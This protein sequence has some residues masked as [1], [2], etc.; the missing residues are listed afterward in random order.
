MQFFLR[1]KSNAEL[2]LRFPSIKVSLLQYYHGQDGPD[3]GEPVVPDV[4]LVPHRE[5]DEGGGGPG[6]PPEPGDLDKQQVR[7]LYR[8]RTKRFIS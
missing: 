2:R 5:Q 4:G 6:Q 1:E 3:H 7:Q 8:T